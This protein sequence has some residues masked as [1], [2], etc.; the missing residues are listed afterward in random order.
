MTRA[1]IPD[2]RDPNRLY[3]RRW[4]LI[5][6]PWFGVYLHRIVLP[7]FDRDPHDHPWNF[8]S[9]VLRGWYREKV[10][11]SHS[12]RQRCEGAISS[13]HPWS[14][15]HLMPLDK[16]H[17]ITD[18]SLPLWTLVFVG[19]RQFDWGF[20][21]KNGWVHWDTYCDAKYNEVEG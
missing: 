10:F 14:S 13:Y 9:V 4:R 8:V 16:A 1:D 7:D 6:T 11:H 5:Q 17:M 12:D 3:L 15:W 19:R 18:I 21:T 2:A 20:W